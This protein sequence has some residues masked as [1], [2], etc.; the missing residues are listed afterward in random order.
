MKKKNTPRAQT[1][2]DTSFG[3]FLSSWA[4][5]GLRWPSL[6]AVGLRGAALAFV[7]H[8]WLPWAFV[9]LHWPALAA[10]GFCG[11]ALAFG[12]RRWLL[13][14]FVVNKM[15][16][17]F[18]KKTHLGPKRRQTRRLGPFCLRGPALAFI[19][20]HWLLWAFVGLRWPS[21]AAVGFRG[22]ALACVGCCGLLWACV[23]LWWPSLAAV[24]LHGPVLAFVDLRILYI[25]KITHLVTAKTTRLAS[26][27]PFF[28]LAAY[29]NPL[30]QFNP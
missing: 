18:S 2:P 17:N 10:V 24:G 1:T 9:G 6:A 20:R 23:G 8:R 15:E 19:G 22:P 12:G 28:S 27:G 29:P 16:E 26:F 4:C 30:R 25:K 7:G 13:W 21:L 5:V 3:P 14:A 11:P